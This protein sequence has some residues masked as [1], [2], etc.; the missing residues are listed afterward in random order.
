MLVVDPFKSSGLV[1]VTI[2]PSLPNQE[3]LRQTFDACSG[4]ESTGSS[5]LALVDALRIQLEC[6]VTLLLQ[7]QNIKNNFANA[8][9][10]FSCI[11]RSKRQS[12]RPRFWISISFDAKLHPL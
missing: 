3:Q 9:S 11:R 1:L 12:S 5:G 4:N 7:M 2:C 8:N 10:I 6:E